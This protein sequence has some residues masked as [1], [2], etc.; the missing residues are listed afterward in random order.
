MLR[1]PR[2][3]LI[4]LAV[5]LT[6][7]VGTFVY[8]NL[9]RSDPPERLTLDDVTTT[10]GD[11]PP[12]S[13]DGL[14]GTW[15]VVEGSIVGYRV[16]AVLFGLDAEAVGRS[17]GVTGSLTVAGTTVTEASF[18]V[19][20]TTFSSDE[21][22]RDGQFNGRIMET[23]QFPTATFVL[24]APIELGETPRDG[25]P[26]TIDTVTGDLTLHGVT[27]S[28][29]LPVTAKL[30]GGALALDGSIEVT[31]GDYGIEDPSAGPAQVGEV[32]ELEVLLV[33]R[34]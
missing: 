16:K 7:I 10:T 4:G 27:R 19:D 30:E 31:F 21:S 33:L 6:P 14:D 25:E 9:I 32:G 24:T 11:A 18:E 3:L 15:Q 23:A 2:W 29:T 20:M 28:V 1:R 34:R 26:L 13:V 17:E 5:L 12:V 22:R 8:L